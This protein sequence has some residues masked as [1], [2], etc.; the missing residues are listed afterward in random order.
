MKQEVSVLSDAAATQAIS[1][2]AQRWFE[3]RGLQANVVLRQTEQFAK[4]TSLSIPQWLEMPGEVNA[5][6][7]KT[8]RLALTVLL[9]DDDL[10]IRGWANEAL[11]K[12]LITRA[13]VLDPF[14][15]AVGGLV[16][17]GLILAG[18]VKKVNRDGVEFYEGVPKE[19][20]DVLKAGA[21]FFQS[22]KG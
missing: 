5:E 6:S 3:A 14:T 22:L 10:E 2:I 16:L 17:A 11:A 13:Q 20:A 15:L 8:C 21:N 7:G 4:R 1:E 18:R 9:E 19:L 12:A